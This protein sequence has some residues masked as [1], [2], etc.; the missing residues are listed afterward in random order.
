MNEDSDGAE[1][2]LVYKFS[3]HENKLLTISILYH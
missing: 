1:N 3:V 2:V